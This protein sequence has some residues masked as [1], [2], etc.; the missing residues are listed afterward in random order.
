M[1]RY[2]DRGVR[3]NLEAYWKQLTAGEGANGV[4]IRQVKFEEDGV[5]CIKGSF[6]ICRHVVPDARVRHVNSAK[7]V[8]R[9]LIGDSPEERRRCSW[10]IILLLDQMTRV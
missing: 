10:A 8:G 5:R 4:G 1:D 2:R 9:R 7:K 3:E 6:D